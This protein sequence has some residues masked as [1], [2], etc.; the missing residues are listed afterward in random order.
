MNTTIALCLAI[1][2]N[3]TLP[4]ATLAAPTAFPVSSSVTETALLAPA[5]FMAIAQ[6]QDVPTPPT[7]S[8]LDPVSLVEPDPDPSLATN[9]REANRD[10][11]PPGPSVALLTPPKESKPVEQ[12]DKF[13]WG[14]FS[15]DLLQTVK[16][17]AIDSR[18]FFLGTLGR[19]WQTL[20]ERYQIQTLDQVREQTD[21]IDQ[22]NPTQPQEDT[23][24]RER[25][26]VLSPDVE[27][28]HLAAL[29]ALDR[30][31]ELSP[32]AFQPKAGVRFNDDGSLTL[33]VLVGN[34]GD[35]LTLI[36]DFNHWGATPNDTNGYELQ[37]TAD[38]PQIHQLTLPPGDY[39]T[40]QY[41]LRDQ[42]GHQRLD[43]TADLYS[44]PAFNQRFAPDRPNQNL[45]AV[46]WKPTPL[47]PEILAERPDLRAKQLVIA[48]T[49]VVALSLKW[50]CDNPQSA[51]HG[52]TGANH[53]S[54]LYQ[55]IG[56][57][58]LPERLAQ[59]G[60]NAVEFMPLDTHVDSWEPGA[61]YNPDWRYNY[62]TIN[63][64]GKHADF[65]TP[66]ELK[67]MVNAFH[68]ANLAV[69]LDV[70]Y[71]H[72][73]NNGNNP[74]R[75]FGPLGFNQ[76]KRDDGGELYGSYFTEWG[77]RRFLYTPEIRRTI[78]DAALI[79][80]L[81]YGF[82]GLRLDNVNGIDSQPEGRTL[83]RELSE[84]IMRYYPQAI[85][86]G[87]GYFGDP[88]LNRSQSIGGA[89]LTTTYSDRFYLWFTGYIIKYCNEIDLWEADYMLNNDWTRALLYYPGN[90]DEFANPG[91]PFQA[92]GRYLVEAIRGGDFHNRKI[93]PWSALTLFAGSYYLDMPQLWTMQ[94]G[95]F[96]ENA[97]IE[98]EQLNHPIVEEVFKFQ[99]D[100]KLF[101]QKNEAFSPRNLHRHIVHWIDHE[102]KVMVFDRID[103]KT[104][105]HTYAIVNLGDKAIKKFK[106]PVPLESAI[107]KIALDSDRSFYGGN[108]HN[109]GYIQVD[110][111]QLS[112]FLGAYGA[113]ALVQ[114]NPFDDDPSPSPELVLSGNHEPRLPKLEASFAIAP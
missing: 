11:D 22:A 75:Q 8:S 14:L 2:L 91:N 31:P 16:Q 96:T 29:E 47:S 15:T 107:F 24:H 23:P 71:S 6:T 55:F 26:Y 82:D 25:T 110:H 63:F 50:T 61:I 9:P 81:R 48:E 67:V 106:F 12:T 32:D 73:P 105:Q 104:G 30:E 70:V 34:S 39:H 76:Y 90:H 84:T 7:V 72:F 85:L 13:G 86:I 51:F 53:I 58:G 77:T 83:L 10:G 44:T 28:L 40:Q 56:E 94:P 97:A 114:S 95:N 66:D 21:A 108:D 46:F 45:N 109:P 5:Q 64:Y 74:P 78:I 17:Q 37:P 89:G 4:S 36:G 100:M 18:N 27:E 111:N 65:G 98:W 103:F 60:Y 3:L 57:C 20:A 35:R 92:R 99:R 112:L 49:D 33:R 42:D 68:Q 19:F 62:Q 43:M 87:E 59:W 113:V 80:V 41:R 52:Q 102:N 93:V 1:L 101:F 69:I 54:Q 79:N 88:Y 38:D